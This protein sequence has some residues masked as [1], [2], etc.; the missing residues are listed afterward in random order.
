MELIARVAVPDIDYL[1][2]YA[3]AGMGRGLKL[4]VEIVPDRVAR[5]VLRYH[6]LY[7]R[8]Q[9]FVVDA[10]ILRQFE[11][12]YRPGRPG[13]GGGFRGCIGLF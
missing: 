6:V 1:R 4:D 13:R 10:A 8:V 7:Q 11:F 2:R 12:H 5:A 3:L 9:V